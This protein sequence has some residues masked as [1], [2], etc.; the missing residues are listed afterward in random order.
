MHIN[1]SALSWIIII[2]IILLI[3]K[4]FKKASS[5]PRTSNQQALVN[6]VLAAI[7]QYAPDFQT[8]KVG[9]AANCRPSTENPTASG[10]IL[11]YIGRSVCFAYDFEEHGYSAG[12]KMWRILA[13]EIAKRYGGK[14]EEITRQT[15]V[16]HSEIA[17]YYVISGRYIDAERERQRN[18]RKC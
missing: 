1:G 15:A 7:D 3:F 11:A 2:V 18:M 6:E 10:G 5:K 16:E 14:Y 9:V 8:I 13:A 12:E 17:G 4:P